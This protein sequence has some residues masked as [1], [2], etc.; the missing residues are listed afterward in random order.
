MNYTPELEPLLRPCLRLILYRLELQNFLNNKR[1]AEE[2]INLE[3]FTFSNEVIDKLKKFK[4]Q[5]EMKNYIPCIDK[6]IEY[7]SKDK[8]DE[9]N[10]DIED[11][12]D[13]KKNIAMQKRKELEQ[14]MQKKREAFLESNKIDV[15]EIATETDH[16][17]TCLICNT[18][19]DVKNTLHGTPLVIFPTR[20]SELTETNYKVLFLNF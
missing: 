13:K 20:I 16:G 8:K 18:A 15:E 5:K 10:I 6:I 2:N 12:F 11:E 19:I 3:D 4:T 17:V 1:K 14:M 9:K 7:T